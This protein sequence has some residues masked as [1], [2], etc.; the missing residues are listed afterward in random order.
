MKIPLCAF[1]GLL[2]LSTLMVSAQVSVEVVLRQEQFLRDESLPL[3]VRIT[4]RSGQP[5][6]LGQPGWLRFTMENLDGYLVAEKA[7][8]E[9]GEEFVLESSDVAERRVDL[10][11]Y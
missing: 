9:V 10:M 2:L 5:L 4:N 6:R 11:P 1:P 7:P 3:A 8:P